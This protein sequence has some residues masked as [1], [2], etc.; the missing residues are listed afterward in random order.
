[1]SGTASIA[2][3]STPIRKVEFVMDMASPCAKNAGK[4]DRK[5]RHV[6]KNIL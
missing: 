1:V 5:I 2:Q 6:N 3:H 4:I